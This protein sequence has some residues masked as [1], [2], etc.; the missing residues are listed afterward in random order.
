MRASQEEARKREAQARH[1]TPTTDPQPLSPITPVNHEA[2]ADN[3]YYSKA[4]APGFF[5][6]FDNVYGIYG[7]DASLFGLSEHGQLGDLAPG[8]WEDFQCEGGS[9]SH[10]PGTNT[11]STSYAI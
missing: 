7:E 8:M 9:I 6:S 4:P 1:I 11:G 2:L 10:D 5:M 3:I